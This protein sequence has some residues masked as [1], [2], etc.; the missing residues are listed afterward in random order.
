MSLGNTVSQLF[1]G[2]IRFKSLYSY[3]SIVQSV[4]AVS[5]M[6]DFCSSLLSCFPGVLLRYFEILT[7]FQLPLLLLISLLF[8]HSTFLL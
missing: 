3:I 4:C 6:A 7:W 2:T 5:D 1:V 8:L